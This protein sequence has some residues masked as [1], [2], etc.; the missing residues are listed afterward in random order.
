MGSA[1][2]SVAI[3]DLH[4]EV[5]L[6]R[7]LIQQIPPDGVQLL[8]LGDYL[9]RGEDSLGTIQFL[10]ELAQERACVFLRGN[11]DAAWLDVWN[12]DRFVRCPAIPGARK[13]WEAAHGQVPPLVGAFLARTHLDWE[14]A[15]A[16]YAHA[17]ALP[18]CSFRK[19]PTEV[20]LWGT[21]TFLTSPYDWGKPVV[22]GHY[23]LTEPLLTPTKCGIDTAA[24]RTGCL[25]ALNVHTRQVIQAAR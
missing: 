16:Y 20:K 7:A 24:Y 9:D 1:Q 17:G 14:D 23:E 21:E 25:T 4:G 6:L 8:F 5:S 15:D 11:H 22:F 2:R 13:V 18:D 10:W 3:G 12:G 19:T